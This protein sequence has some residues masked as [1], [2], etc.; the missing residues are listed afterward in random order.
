MHAT[1]RR[2]QRF[3][4]SNEPQVLLNAQGESLQ[5]VLP[6]MRLMSEGGTSI[7]NLKDAKNTQSNEMQGLVGLNFVNK[8]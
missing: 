3:A 2:F 4:A 5:K 1:V 7:M 8:Y 6:S